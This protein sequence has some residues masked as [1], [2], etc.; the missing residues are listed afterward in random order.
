MEFAPSSRSV[1]PVTKAQLRRMQAQ[2]AKAGEYVDKNL[3]KEETEKE[4]AK[5]ELDSLLDTL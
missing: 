1:K 2:F 5:A 4:R 3:E